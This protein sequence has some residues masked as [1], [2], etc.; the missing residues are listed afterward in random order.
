M[1]LGLE[2]TSARM[3]RLARAMMFDVPLLSLDEMLER[4]D[5]VSADEVAE[6]AGRALRPRDSSPPPAS[7][8]TRTASER[9]R[10]SV[11]AAL[12]A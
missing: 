7:G 3:G 4:V 1:V 11:S 9:R 2:A 6:L 12:V 5:A 10:Q 8:P